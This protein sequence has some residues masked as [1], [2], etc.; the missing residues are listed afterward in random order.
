MNLLCFDPGGKKN[1]SSC[2]WANFDLQTGYLLDYGQIMPEDLPDLLKQLRPK[3]IIAENYR[4]M[5]WKR[6]AQNWSDNT[7]SRVIGHLEMWVALDDNCDE[8]ILQEPANKDVGVAIS[9]VKVPANHDMGHQIMAYGHGVFYIVKN[10]IRRPAEYHIRG[11][12][13]A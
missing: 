9:G 2:G 3:K 1:K 7:A 4:N 10:K 5:P 6:Q 13:I 12:K 11:E 8:L